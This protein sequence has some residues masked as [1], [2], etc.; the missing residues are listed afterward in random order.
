[1]AHSEQLPPQAL[2]SI[3]SQIADREC[4]SWLALADSY[5][6]NDGADEAKPILQKILD[7][8]GKTSWAEDAKKR[9]AKMKQ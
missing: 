7:K 9:L 3:T 1:M 4:R 6:M 5:I 2:Q 8:Y